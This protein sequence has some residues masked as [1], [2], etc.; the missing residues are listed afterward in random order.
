MKIKYYLIL[1]LFL[2]IFAYSQDTITR[3]KWLRFGVNFGYASQNT[4]VKQ[5]SDYSYNSKIIKAYQS[6]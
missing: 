2:S 4:F 5:E 6:F 3:F 1:S